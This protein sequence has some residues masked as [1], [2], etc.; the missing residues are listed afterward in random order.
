MQGKLPMTPRYISAGMTRRVC[1][2]VLAGVSALPLA[3]PVQAQAAVDKST[4]LEE[5]V[6]TAQRRS[7]A[8]QS[9]P[10]QVAAFSAARIEDA[11]YGDRKSVV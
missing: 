4:G 8:L 10:I 5:I 9:V 3:G 7:E 2:T 1:V 6:V 11:L